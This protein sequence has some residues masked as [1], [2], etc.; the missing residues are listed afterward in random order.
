MDGVEMCVGGVCYTSISN[1]TDQ[2][3]CTALKMYMMLWGGRP[4]T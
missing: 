4:T 2:A 1:W 3:V